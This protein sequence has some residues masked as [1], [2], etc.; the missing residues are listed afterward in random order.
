MVQ[1]VHRRARRHR[2]DARHPARRHRQPPRDE[3]RHPEDIAEAVRHRPARRAGAAL[4]LGVVNGERFAVMAGTGFDALMIRD[5]DRGLKDTRRPPRLRVDRCANLRVEP[6]AGCASTS[7]ATGG[8]RATRRCVLVGNVG[9]ILGGIDAF[10]DAEPDDG[11]LEVGR[12]HR[13]RAVAVGAG[14]RAAWPRARP[15]GRR[16]SRR[17]R[18]TKVD[19]GSTRKMPYELDGGDR[20]H[21][22]AAEGAGR[23]GARIT[24]CVP[25]AETVV[26]TANLVPETWELDRRRR[27]RDAAAARAAAACSPTPSSGCGWPTASATPARWPS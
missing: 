26:S 9:T 13:R 10:D 19:V 27:H 18:R 24:V 25:E 21:D 11:R 16:S 23:A 14:A 5:A 4:D 12:R 15:S 8:S 6:G 2:R 7:T 20:T 3:P 22:Q 17:R 1:R